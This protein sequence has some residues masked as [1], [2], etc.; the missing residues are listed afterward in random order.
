M[1][2]KRIISFLLSLCP[3]WLQ[4]QFV[5][6]DWDSARGDSLL[7]VCVSVVD[8]PSDYMDYSYSAHIEYPEYQK[9]TAEEVARYR[10][11][12]EY[13]ELPSQPYVEC[14]VGV[15]AK[16][17]Q[18]DMAFLPVVLRDGE[19]YRLNSY[20]L[21]VD[22]TLCARQ[23][24]SFARSAG[25]RYAS[26]SVLAEGRWVRISVKE[27]GIHKITDAELKK[28][29]FQN[30]GNVRLFGYGG[31][32][33]PEEGIENLPD[34]LQEVPLWREN[35]FVLFY[36]NGVVKWSY[37]DGRFVHEQNVYSNYGCYFLTEGNTPMPFLSEKI[38]R[39][40]TQVVSEYPDYAVIDNDKKSHCQYGRVL[41]DSHDYSTQRTVEYKFPVSGVS[42]GNG[43]IDISFAT[44]GLARSEVQLVV[45]NRQIGKYT[46]G[47][48]TSGEIGK[49]VDEKFVTD[50]VTD[51]ISLFVVQKTNDKSVNGFLDY[52]RL[53]Y[54]RK[55]A[56]RGSQ[57]AFRGGSAD[58][59]ATFEIDGCA[60]SARVWDVSSPV[61]R[62]LKGVLSGNRYSVVAP[63]GID[64][65]YVVVDIN[66][67]FPSVQVIG[68]VANQNLHSIEKA[69]MVI[70]IPSNGVFKS[71]AEK[72]A[73]AHRGMDGLVVEVV[74]AQQVYNEF[75]SGTPDVTAYR[76]FMKMLYDRAATSAD[77]PKY[78]LMLGDSWY[79]NRLITFPKYRQDDYLLC[80]ES[81]NSVDAVRSYVFEDY[82]GLLDDGEGGNN[83]RDKVD[84]GVGRIPVTSI[85]VADAIVE[86]IIAYMK[87]EDAGAWQNVVALLGD[88]GDVGIPNQHMKDAE[89]VAN[90]MS[91]NFPSYIVDRI[92]WD[93]FVAEK[94]AVGLRYPEVTNAI[95]NRLDKGALVV[96]YSGHGSTNLLSHEMSWKAS[97]MAELKSPRL[98]FWVTASCDIGPFDKG[99][100][101]IAET[102]LMNPSGAAV[103][104]FT[105][106]RTVLQSYNAILNK[107][108][109]K[110]LL[111]PV[112]GGSAVAVG[113]AVRQAK[114][115]VISLG[116]DL[117]ENKLQYVLL[118][119]PALRL[120][121]PEYRVCIDKVNGAAV[122]TP[123]QASAGGMLLLE[124]RI[125]TRTGA[126]VNDF[127]GTLYANL[128]DC[129]VDVTTLDNS[130][131][132]SFEYTA[133]NKM[134]FSGNGSVAEGCFE[135]KIPVPMDI[136]YSNENGMLNLFAV[137]SDKKRSAQGYFDDFT[138]GGTA[139]DF[140]NDGV[141]PE[142]RLYLNTTSFVNGDKV[143]ST[144]CLLVELFDENG[145]NTVGSG[146]GHNITA[147][148][149]N[150]PAHTY[151]LNSL[152]E[153]SA[154]DYRRGTITFPLN[155]LEPGE[156]TLM[157]RAW[158]LYN[159][160]SLATI[161]FVVEPGLLP[162][163]LEFR[164]EG[165]PVVNGK[166]SEFV[167]VHNRPQ[168][169]IE[170]VIELFS[171][172]GQMLW[173]SVEKTVCDGMEYRYSW[174]GTADGNRPL[175]TGVY[176]VRAYVVSDDGVSKS[177]SLKL[178][179]VNNK[180]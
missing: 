25:E 122:G 49:L 32:I 58:G 51:N 109:M 96:N 89:G 12:T 129:A 13:A 141:G 43:V 126:P 18:L 46:I 55:L 90:I 37:A 54:T 132:G 119:D 26:N 45:G 165:T 94:T 40:P 83:K 63:S 157:L 77:A 137:D 97:D 103:G 15:Q 95:R 16:Q 81:V 2:V 175:S 107:E 163:V 160:S 173:K 27:N 38:D 79:D 31:H 62:E 24:T 61:H 147:V 67:Q 5:A 44:N 133:Y 116:S 36:A 47:A 86:K 117:S 65:E 149:D 69:D 80:Y 70:I 127:E 174:N 35:G 143:N 111:S 98:P 28:M 93:D 71:V 14:G 162:D 167:I 9:M 179:V 64:K 134:L 135:M 57:T 158:D 124:G 75:S 155:E 7:P 177:K 169:E 125:V 76:R 138:V 102:A 72:L 10:L 73:E 104:L 50:A 144:P 22:K 180:K 178:I 101:S 92:Y 91:K 100:N 52:L 74:T 136:S 19:Y 21:V 146:I 1:N 159:N 60:S 41:V 123:V 48:N 115:N 171:I 105:T 87:N 128:F 110:V 151:N 113:D 154:T 84:I 106:T 114:C 88:D 59:Y 66:G 140:E 131:L 145:I 150:D 139:A 142:I 164:V 120:K 176:V 153:P 118:G 172:Q 29:G 161:N 170:A 6:V 53:N 82:M 78:L 42:K 20:K 30:P 39:Q 17:P 148:V 152:Y 121:L 8:L 108:F 4:A 112:N 23:R 34:D 68:E 99:D 11:R 168:S 156:H 3:L 56:L 85:S 33:L 130:Q 166:T